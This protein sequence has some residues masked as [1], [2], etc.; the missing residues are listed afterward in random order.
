MSNYRDRYIARGIPDFDPAACA[1]Y[2]VG[3]VPQSGWYLIEPAGTY[4]IP[5]PDTSI[6]PGKRWDVD[7]VIDA[8]SLLIAPGLIDPHVQ[9]ICESYDPAINGGNGIQVNNDHLHLRTTGDNPALGWC[10]ALDYGRVDGS[11]YQAAYIAWVKDTH[12]D[13]NQGKYWAFSTEY[14]LADYKRVYDAPVRSGRHQQPGP[15]GPAGHHP[16]I[17]C[18]RCGRPQPQCHHLPNHNHE[19]E[20]NTATGPALRRCRRR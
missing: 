1:P 3:Q 18:R 9:A 8:S 20:S 19:Q 14:K 12:H 16:P 17:R 5:V 6:A 4:T 10:K 15:R 2:P 11:L 13:L 7:E